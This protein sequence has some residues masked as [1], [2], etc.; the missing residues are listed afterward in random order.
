MAL[1]GLATCYQSLG[2]P[3]HFLEFARRGFA[4]T[5]LAEDPVQLGNAADLLGQAWLGKGD[6]DAARRYFTRALE[7]RRQA[8]RR[9]EAADSE[10]NLAMLDFREGRAAEA[11]AALDRVVAQRRTPQRFA[12]TRWAT[13]SD[14]EG[15]MFGVDNCAVASLILD[16]W[17]FPAAVG[18][19]IRIHYLT[20]PADHENPLAALLNVANGLAA[21]VSRAFAGETRWW[22][23]TDDKLHAARLTVDDFE[24]AIMETEAAFDAAMAVLK[25]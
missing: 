16:E 20:R 7:L 12:P 22:D 23:I 18:E 19:S 11:L 3:D 13:Y 8:G 6:L 25:T 14:W 2:D 5:E 1:L 9:T 4:A 10:H 24:P 21:R 17:R 15:G